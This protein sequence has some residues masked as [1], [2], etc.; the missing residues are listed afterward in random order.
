MERKK[1]AGAFTHD[2]MLHYL[3][4]TGDAYRRIDVPFFSLS[5]FFV[6]HEE[7]QVG[8]VPFEGMHAWH[9]VMF[10]QSGLSPLDDALYKHL[11]G[12]AERMNAYVFIIGA[13]LF[14]CPSK[15]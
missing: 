1:I 14:C 11:V 10:A 7:T 12:V 3:Q 15:N 8:L 6:N 5:H 13:D 9:E 2:H 4:L